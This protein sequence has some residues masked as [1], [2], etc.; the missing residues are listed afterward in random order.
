M[1]VNGCGQRADAVWLPWYVRFLL[2]CSVRQKWPPIVASSDCRSAAFCMHG[3]IASPSCV[4]LAAARS[5]WRHGKHHYARWSVNFGSFVAT[6]FRRDIC[7]V[8][9]QWG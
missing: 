3:L 1:R 9:R 2:C 8:S 5:V 4:E 6:E 7:A